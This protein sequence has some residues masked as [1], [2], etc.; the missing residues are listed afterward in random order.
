MQRY[1]IP[2]LLPF[3]APSVLAD[4]FGI[5][6][7]PINITFVDVGNAGNVAQSNC[8]VISNLEI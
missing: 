6:T 3:L 5:G 2:I 7:N 1:T 8:R 4:T